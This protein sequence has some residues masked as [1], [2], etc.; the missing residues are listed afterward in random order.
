MAIKTFTVGEV[1]TASDTNTYLANSGLV[2][3]SGATFTNVASFDI[4]GFTNTYTFFQAVLRVFRTSG[5]GG[6]GITATVRDASSGYTTNGYFGAGWRVLF[7]GTS[8]AVATRNNAADMDV[9]L[10]QSSTSPMLSTM[11][12]TGMNTTSSQFMITGQHFDPANSGSTT[13]GFQNTNTTL[14]LDRIRFACG[15][16]MTGV[17]RLYGYREP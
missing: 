14:S 3:V 2:Y 7:N 5:T 8:S 6:A 12:I 4:T 16:N 17:W 15:V 9:G 13:W 11:Q 10:V 1:L